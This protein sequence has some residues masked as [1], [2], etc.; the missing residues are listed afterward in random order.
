MLHLFY[1]KNLGKL[2]YNVSNKHHVEEVECFGKFH[3]GY[4][5]FQSL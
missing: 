5:I 1:C 2:Y 3:E 4:S